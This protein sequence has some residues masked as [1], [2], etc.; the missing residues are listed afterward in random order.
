MTKL[1]MVTGFTGLIKMTVSVERS[2]KFDDD[3]VMVPRTVTLEGEPVG[4]KPEGSAKPK[5]DT[6]IKP[7]VP[8][9]SDVAPD[10][11]APDH[12]GDDFEPV[13]TAPETLADPETRPKRIRKESDYI[14]LL[15]TGEW[16]TGGRKN[17]PVVPKGLQLVEESGGVKAGGENR[18]EAEEERS[19]ETAA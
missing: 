5:P 13:P 19:G 6:T 8:T 11:P 4:S 10:H 2:V 14:K 9:S 15:R 12:L 3:W 1:V 7:L 18:E 17:T 16:S